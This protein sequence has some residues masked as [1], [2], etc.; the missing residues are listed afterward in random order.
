VPL[1]YQTED[2]DADRARILRAVYPFPP[3]FCYFPFFS[4]IPHLTPVF[5]PLFKIPEIRIS[6]ILAKIPEIRQQ[7]NKNM[8]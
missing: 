8:K 5:Y 3:E 2:K 4:C 7:S 1:S 6:G